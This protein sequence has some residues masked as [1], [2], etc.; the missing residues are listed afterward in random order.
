MTKSAIERLRRLFRE[1]AARLPQVKNLIIVDENGIVLVDKLP[2][3]DRIRSLQG[4]FSAPSWSPGSCR[5]CQQAGSRQ[6]DRPLGCSDNAQDSDPDGTFAGVA[7]ATV[8]VS[9]FQ[10][11][12]QRFDLGAGAARSCSP[13]WTEPCW[14]GVPSRMPPWAGICRKAASFVN[15]CRSQGPHG[16]GEIR[17]SPTASFAS[18][19]ISASTPTPS[20]VGGRRGQG[21]SPR[22]LEREGQ[23]WRA[24]NNRNQRDH[25]AP[26]FCSVAPH[27]QDRR[28]RRPAESD[29]R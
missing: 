8:S 27:P 20:P 7:M 28:A 26:W 17:S 16:S 12:D 29:P 21:R 18:T 3:T 19:A 23:G 6:D 13:L 5:A 25:R 2:T 10:Q 1:E 9:Y 14:S 15:S 4:V 24:P 22:T 11:V